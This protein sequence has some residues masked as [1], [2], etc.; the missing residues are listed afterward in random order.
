MT[1]TSFS[2][3]VVACSNKTVQ[4]P[5][6]PEQEYYE[7]A[8]AALEDGLPTTAAKHLK[9]LTSRYP[10]GEYTIRAELDLIYSYL[11]AGD[12][13]A[14][15]VNVERFIKNHPDHSS[16]DY[17]YYMRGL[18]TYKSTE[19]FLG[20]YIALDPSERDVSELTTSFNEF[21]L[22]LERY[23]NSQYAPDAKARMVYLRNIIARHELQVA[24][25]YFKRKAPLSAL[26]RGQTVLEQYPSSDSI[27]DALGVIIQAYIDLGQFDLAQN[28]IEVLRTSYPTSK[29]LDKDD[30]FISPRLPKDA[31][32]DF[33]YWVTLGAID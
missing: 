2:L 20:R 6:L 21:S 7:K 25:Y 16:L 4:E 15:H 30:K 22:L 26:R 29:F 8:Q 9:D 23:P 27:E 11:S 3:L 18:I 24:N 12:F 28:N 10:F 32:P 19:S 14:A 33:L 1:I 5:D 17:A 13:I 31:D